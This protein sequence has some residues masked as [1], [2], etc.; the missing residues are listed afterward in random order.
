MFAQEGATLAELMQRGGHA[1][2]RIVLRYQHATMSRDRE[3]ADRMSKRVSAM[4]S[5]ASATMGTGSKPDASRLSW[6][7]ARSSRR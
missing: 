7:A 6:Q 5:A 4:F 3:L 1:D 2:I